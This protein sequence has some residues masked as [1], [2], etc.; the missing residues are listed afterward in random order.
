MRL[1]QYY[2]FGI[3]LFWINIATAQFSDQWPESI[4]NIQ[5]SLCLVEY[6]QPQVEMNEIKDQ[7]RIKHK[8]SGILVKNNGLVVTSDVIF[9]ASLDII[10]DNNLF[11]MMQKSP[12]D[13]TISFKKDVKIKATFLGKDEEFGL[14]FIQINENKDLPRA[15]NF[16]STGNFSIGDYIYI[17]EHLNRYYEYEKIITIRNVNSIIKKPRYTLL[18]ST[19]L[20]PLSDGGLV[21]NSNGKAIGIIKQSSNFQNGF[22]FDYGEPSGNSNLSE[23]LLARHFT[24]LIQK[25][26]RVELH[27]MEG[28]KSWLGIQM[29]VLTRE[30]SEYWGLHVEGGIIVNNVL[31]NSPAEKSGV[32]IGDIITDIDK[33]SITGEDRR[34]LEIFRNYVRSLPAKEIEIKI[35]RNQKP[36][37]IIVSL[38]NTPISQFLAKEFSNEKLGINVKELTQDIIIN[39]D[40]DFD[41]EGVWVSKVEE[42]GAVDLAGLFINDLILRINDVKIKNL[43]VFKNTINQLILQNPD[44][45]QFF[46]KRNNKSQFLFIKLSHDH[47]TQN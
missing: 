27:N 21:L 26:P 34:N 28:G 2:I 39:N 38:E 33:L 8:I 14:A 10:A 43:S 35:L 3:V 17:I 30:I 45:I 44:Y 46:I 12:E 22:V 4:D 19:N 37:S 47:D 6:Y 41:I 25:P 23:V 40:L 1:S 15:V 29:Q 20:S 32:K 11:S 7:T 31:P 13:I 18:T 16:D 5:Q 24:K 9:P 42:A 36:Q